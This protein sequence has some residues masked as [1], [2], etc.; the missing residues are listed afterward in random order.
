MEW[1]I[2]ELSLSG[3]FDSPEEFRV[4]LEALLK[5]RNK[6]PYYN[7]DYIAALVSFKLVK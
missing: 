3:Q 5:L 1:H 4:A 2:N 6:E 7:A